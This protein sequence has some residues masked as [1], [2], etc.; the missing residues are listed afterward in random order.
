ML[1]SVRNLL[2]TKNKN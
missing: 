1:H 2:Q